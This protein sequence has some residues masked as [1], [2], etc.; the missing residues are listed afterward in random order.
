[1]APNLKIF[2]EILLFDEKLSRSLNR[3]KKKKER[4]TIYLN[5]ISLL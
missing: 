3:N 2:L 4:Y 1:M 5:F